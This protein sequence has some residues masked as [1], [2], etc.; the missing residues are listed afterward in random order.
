MD[1]Y[2]HGDQGS[3]EERKEDFYPLKAVVAPVVPNEEYEMEIDLGVLRGEVGQLKYFHRLPLISGWVCS[4]H[5]QNRCIPPFPTP[6]HT[7]P[8]LNML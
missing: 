6:T 7:L 3:E 5:L 2:L 4:S 8:A 1:S